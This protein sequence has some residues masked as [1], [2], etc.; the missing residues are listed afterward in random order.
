VQHAAIN[1]LDD[2]A[3]GEVIGIPLEVEPFKELRVGLMVH[4]RRKPTPAT[5]AF[6]DLL[7]ARLTELGAQVER[8]V[9]RGAGGARMKPRQA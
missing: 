6:L 3:S 9:L 4:R 7:R 1:R 5:S 8:L 2:L